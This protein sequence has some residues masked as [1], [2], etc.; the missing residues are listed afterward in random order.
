VCVG[1]PSA[2]AAVVLGN[3]DI[4]NFTVLR[5]TLAQVLLVGVEGHVVDKDARALVL[6]GDGRLGGLGRRGRAERLG[7]LDGVVN[8][9]LLLVLLG[10]AR[11]LG[12][13]AGGWG[14]ERRTES[15]SGELQGKGGARLLSGGGGQRRGAGSS[16][17]CA[18]YREPVIK[19]VINVDPV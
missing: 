2:H 12:K 7:G 9:L 19:L 1:L 5:E 16:Q 6:G 11:R 15:G 17:G 13:Q 10:A 18:S 4:D 3:V 14:H 8:R